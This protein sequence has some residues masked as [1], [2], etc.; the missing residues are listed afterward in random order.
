MKSSL[1]FASCLAV[2]MAGSI[3][4][5]P[6][7]SPDTTLLASGGSQ[8]PTLP[9]NLAEVP[10][11]KVP[12]AEHLLDNVK[13]PEDFKALPPVT[14]YLH[15]SKVSVNPWF[16]YSS[17]FKDVPAFAQYAIDEASEALSSVKS[18]S[19]GMPALMPY[20][21]VY[22]VPYRE[23]LLQNVKTPKDLEAL[24]KVTIYIHGVKAEADPWLYYSH[25]FKDLPAFADYHHVAKEDSA[26][27]K[28]PSAAETALTFGEDGLPTNLDSIPLYKV[29][30]PE[31]LVHKVKT[32]EDFNRLPQ[33]VYYN[34]G[35]KI[36]VSPWIVY[37]NR[38][39]GLPEFSHYSPMGSIEDPLP[40]YISQIPWYNASYPTHL[41]EQA[42]TEEE[43]L[44]LPDA[45][46]YRHGVPI[47]IP[48][49]MM[50]MLGD[51]DKTATQHQ[52]IPVMKHSS[53]ITVPPLPQEPSASQLPEQPE[54]KLPDNL[55]SLV[56]HQ[57]PYNEK[58]FDSIDSFE[59][60]LKLPSV[61]VYVYGKMST[62]PAWVYYF[63]RFMGL[64]TAIPDNEEEASQDNHDMESKRDVID[65]YLE[66]SHEGPSETID[67][68]PDAAQ[69]TLPP[70]LN[71]K[72][73]WQAPYPMKLLDNV[74]NL[75]DLMNLPPA[76]VYIYGHSTNMPAYIVFQDRFKTLA[77]PQ[78]S[79][80]TNTPTMTG[81]ED[82]PA[83]ITAAPDSKLPDNLKELEY[84][85]VPYDMRPVETAKGP[86]DF[87]Y[88]PDVIYY[89]YG[90]KVVI[91]AWMYFTDKIDVM[92]S[93][94]P[95]FDIF[96]FFNSPATSTAH[97]PLSLSPGGPLVAHK[98]SNE[99]PTASQTLGPIITSAPE[100][101]L[102]DNLAELAFF[103]VPYDQSLI[104]NIR[105]VE[106]LMNLPPAV[107]YIYGHSTNMPAYIVFQDRF[108][109]LAEPQYST[110]TM[111]G[112]EDL[113]AMITAAPDFKLPDNLKEIEYYD[114]PYDMRPVEMAKHPEDFRYLPDVIYYHYGKKVVI[115]AWMYFTD[116]IDVMASTRPGFDIFDFFNS[117][118]TS[119]AHR[120]LSLSPRGPVVAHKGSN[121][122]PTA[123]QTIDPVITS[124]PEFK[125]PDNL[126]ELPFFEVPYDQSLIDKIEKLEDFIG[127]PDCTGYTYGRKTVIP[128]WMN[129][130]KKLIEVSKG[131]TSFAAHEF[132][133]TTFSASSSSGPSIVPRADVN[134]QP[135][136]TGAPQATAASQTSYHVAAAGGKMDLP[137][138]LH[139]IPRFEVPYDMSLLDN[140]KTA[141]DLANLPDAIVFEYGDM[142][143]VP[144]IQRFASKLLELIECSTISIDPLD[145]SKP[146]PGLATEESQTSTTFSTIIRTTLSASPN[147]SN[148]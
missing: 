27:N 12:Y 92:A 121:E 73:F 80:P 109:T 89:H 111:T 87:R 78:Y 64:E 143:R 93:T 24:P 61:I 56:F 22:Q 59:D 19:A 76:L 28:A 113:P 116:R 48:A 115:P 23:E 67:R 138:N 72:S 114:V 144:A 50:F 41:I 100:F 124:A 43:I 139:D 102:P 10:I 99:Q 17:R 54:A 136:V 42:K 40:A 119:T 55:E 29:D 1:F 120:P 20:M 95:G 8:E 21:P 18:L 126:A 147:T 11:Y 7:I 112:N 52:A 103:Q 25:R 107:V 145:I 104:E 74:R 60:Y 77:E 108:K 30:Y 37:G 123:S 140:V 66:D 57:V 110:P 65:E 4:T 14:F 51:F 83:M 39:A 117:P 122:Q 86:E 26:S 137:D 9:S 79:T 101:K 69:I 53:D 94:R 90:R 135:A 49:W 131:R 71:E 58:V 127:L 68:G 148:S 133:A 46:V 97:R 32:P 62:V 91:P 70:D 130:H 128:A 34:N 88:L 105:N 36:E 47:D 85:Y 6:D 82:L 15:G 31:D 96:D 106:D 129:F 2:A 146:G 13:T 35:S 5:V 134:D 44:K 45:V 33:V 98:G 125:L 81:N 3:E 16:Y 84:Y 141:E 132:F 142:R 63:N 118:A 38:F 75:E